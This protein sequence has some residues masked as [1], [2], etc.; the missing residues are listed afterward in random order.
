[1]E[2]TTDGLFLDETV[3]IVERILV[4]VDLD[5]LTRNGSIGSPEPQRKTPIR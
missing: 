2:R 4:R 5:V 1:M 3:K